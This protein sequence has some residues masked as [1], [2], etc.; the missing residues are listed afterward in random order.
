MLEEEGHYTVFAP[1]NEAFE[2]IPPQTLTRIMGDPIALRGDVNVMLLP[3][4][5]PAHQSIGKN[6]V[7]TLLVQSL[8]TSIPW[9]PLA[10][11]KTIT[12]TTYKK[13]QTVA[14]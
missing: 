4:H 14:R 2:K 6:K 9:L 5:T 13:G 7:C 11:P 12:R 8:N 3:S 1:T 10:P